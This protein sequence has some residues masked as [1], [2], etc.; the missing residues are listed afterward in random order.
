MARRQVLLNPAVKSAVVRGVKISRLLRLRPSGPWL[1]RRNPKLRCKVQRH[2]RLRKPLQSGLLFRC[3]CRVLLRHLQGR[4][5]CPCSIF[6]PARR[7]RLFLLSALLNQPMFRQ[8]MFRQPMFRCRQVGLGHRWRQ[9]QFRRKR[10]RQH[11][12][13]RQHWRQ[14]QHP[15]QRQHRHRLQRQYKSRL[16][17]H[18]LCRLALR[19]WKHRQLPLQSRQKLCRGPPRQSL[20][21]GL[22]WR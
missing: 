19:R 9:R 15:H 14:R 5:S 11:R 20:R 16:S 13:Q 3:R 22:I 21:R 7:A 12:R 8:P 18:P 1:R 4:A 2:R 17:Q 6:R 10:R